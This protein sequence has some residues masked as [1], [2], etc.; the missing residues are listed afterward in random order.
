MATE[1]E[2]RLRALLLEA[3]EIDRGASAAP[4]G[5]LGEIIDEQ[6]RALR[7]VLLREGGQMT[8]EEIAQ[9]SAFTTAEK[10]RAPGRRIQ[11]Q[12][13]DVR[14]VYSKSLTTPH[15]TLPAG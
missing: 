2:M 3:D 15:G 14:M 4:K 12:G 5:R 1:S 10:R 6:R 7:Q 11:A 9:M 8:L 13:R